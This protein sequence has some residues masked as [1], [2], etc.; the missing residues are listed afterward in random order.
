MK[1]EEAK[2]QA[3]RITREADIHRL[4][5]AGTQRDVLEGLYSAEEVSKCI[6]KIEEEKAM[7]AMAEDAKDVEPLHYSSS[8]NNKTEG[9]GGGGNGGGNAAASAEEGIEEAKQEPA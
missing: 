3:A 2:E 7:L 9:E 5:D 8:N 4:Y 6:A 1:D